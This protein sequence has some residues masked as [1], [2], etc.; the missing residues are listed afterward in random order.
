[1]V[2][3]S[4]AYLAIRHLVGNIIITTW[5]PTRYTITQSLCRNQGG[6]D[7]QYFFFCSPRLVPH[8]GQSLAT[9]WSMPCLRKVTSW[10][11]WWSN[12]LSV[13]LALTGPFSGAFDLVVIR[14]RLLNP[15][16][17]TADVFCLKVLLMV[18]PVG[19][20]LLR[21]EG[22]RW[23]TVLIR[24]ACVCCRIWNW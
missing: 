9:T 16:V 22:A 8:A 24:P 20:L 4:H 2:N 7:T 19:C 23:F 3:T 18:I 13:V 11:K 15:D 12:L 5:A 1:M 21:V 10:G 17:T 14:L 6:T